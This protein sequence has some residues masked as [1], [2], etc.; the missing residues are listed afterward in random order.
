[1]SWCVYEVPKVFDQVALRDCI[2]RTVV[3]KK[4][5]DICHPSFTFE[6]A[7]D[8]TIVEV[9]VISKTD[10]LTKPGYKKLKLFV[11]LRY[12]IHYSD[13]SEQL[14]QV[15]EAAFNLTVNEIYCPNC[16]SQ[17]GSAKSC[18]S[19]WDG[20]KKKKRSEG[21]GSI[22]K[23]EALAE[24]FN[25]MLN[26]ATG[27]LTLDVGVFFVVKCECVVQLLIP[28]YGYCPVPPEQNISHS[29]NCKTF[30]DKKKTPFP[31]KFF[32]EQKWNPLDQKEYIEE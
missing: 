32:P 19:F 15:D 12:T 5:G 28:S 1:M 31:T 30:V 20:S 2:T 13:G 8:F 24:A 22:I 4:G 16:I 18:D 3:L 17:S 26:Q 21:E 25:D 11:K 9:K 10:S 29:Q 14:E 27:M 6:G 23:V 7:T